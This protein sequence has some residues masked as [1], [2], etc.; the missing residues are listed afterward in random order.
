MVI[1]HLFPEDREFES[2]DHKLLSLMT[3]DR[4]NFLK[5]GFENDA[6]PHSLQAPSLYLQTERFRSPRHLEAVN[7][8]KICTVT[9]KDR[10]KRK[11]E[12]QDQDDFEHRD[13]DS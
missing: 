2:L 13:I 1:G 4:D 12:K 5:M 7:R 3:P 9:F 8:I 6:K 11:L 10:Q